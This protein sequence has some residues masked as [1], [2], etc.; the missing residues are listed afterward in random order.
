MGPL[1]ATSPYSVVYGMRTTHRT[2]Y[3][4][5]TPG[6]C[7]RKISKFV[8]PFCKF[9]NDEVQVEIEFTVASIIKGTRSLFVLSVYAIAATLLALE[10]AVHLVQR[11]DTENFRGEVA[12]NPHS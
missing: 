4:T 5:C 2:S 8:N 3:T 10:H 11:H 7:V 1:L 9:P 12:Q 6:L